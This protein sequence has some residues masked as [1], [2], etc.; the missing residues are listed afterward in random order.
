MRTE[1]LFIRYANGDA[2]VMDVIGAMADSE[3]EKTKQIVEET[4]SAL[5]DLSVFR[6]DFRKALDDLIDSGINQR[7][8]N[9]VDSYMKPSLEEYMEGSQGS[10]AGEKR[11]VTVKEKDTPW[12]EAVVC[13]NL[14]LYMRMYGIQDIKHC[15]VCGKFFSHKGKYAK[16]CSDICKG[17][18]SE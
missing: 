4:K 12:V 8:I 9:Y 5:P 2:T 17:Q 3:D 1:P 14:C 10:R 18:K 13:Y 7:L 6:A 15:P 16:Y 11:W